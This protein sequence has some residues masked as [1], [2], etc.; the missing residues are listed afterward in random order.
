MHE[1]TVYLYYSNIPKI[2]I[3]YL[4]RLH[5]LPRVEV[6]VIFVEVLHTELKTFHALT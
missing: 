5:V 4:R 6:W 3:I 2:D 1:K